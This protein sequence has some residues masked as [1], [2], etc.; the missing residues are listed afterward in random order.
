MTRV[1]LVD[2]H[3]VV[4]SGI[5]Y[6]LEAGGYRVVGEAKSGEE[7]L[8]K[9]TASDA[10]I[11]IIDISLPGMNG[12]ELAQKLHQELPTLKLLALSVNEEPTLIREFL[13]AGGMGYVPKSGVEIELLDAVAALERG[14][15]FLPNRLLPLL[16]DASLASS[17]D[18]HLLTERELQVVREIAR[19]RT[20]REIAQELGISEKTVS[21]YRERATEKL[22]LRTRAAL[23][24]WALAEGLID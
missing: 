4:R 24:R 17:P 23:V 1:F 19:G 21:T 16:A 11:A 3:P 6:L 10:I 20:Y 13:A 12:I 14:E 18:K 5:R 8:E 15:Y 7:A 9:L 22:G 2:D